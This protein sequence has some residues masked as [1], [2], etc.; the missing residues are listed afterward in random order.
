M[1]RVGIAIFALG[2]AAVTALALAD[3]IVQPASYHDFA[4]QRA[5]GG[6]PHAHNVLSNLTFLIA[7]V[8]G[9]ARLPRDA[10][11]AWAVVFGASIAIASG[12]AWYHLA[13][14]DERL[15]WDRLPIG[16][17]FAAYF[18]ALLHE[19]ADR[20][21]GL[22]AAAAFSSFAVLAVYVAYATG[23]LRLWILTQGIPL[24][25]TPLAL[26]LSD[27]RRP[28]DGYLWLTFAAYALAKLAEALDA[29]LYALTAGALSG[30]V[31]KHLLAGGGVAC[32]WLRLETRRTRMAVTTS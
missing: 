30:H 26:M 25:A 21:V 12:S 27:G 18:A 29:E 6:L 28:G 9:L 4:D 7:G 1:N 2:V 24:F 22:S 10:H 14:T 11:P 19:Y 20:R 15:I 13:P 16:L 32:L 31:V 8:V 23:D 5:L 17:A 3:P